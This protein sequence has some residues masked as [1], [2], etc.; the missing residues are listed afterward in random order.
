MREMS[1]EEP[2]L[3]EETPLTPNLKPY[4]FPHLRQTH[5]PF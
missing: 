3:P 5:F 4:N 2:I 1:M